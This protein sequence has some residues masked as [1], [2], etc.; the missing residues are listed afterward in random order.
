MHGDDLLSEINTKKTLEF[1]PATIFVSVVIVLG[2][3][4]NSMSLAFY[5]WKVAKTSTNFF[6]CALSAVDLITCFVLLGEVI[7]L[8]YVVNFPSVFLCK[9]LYFLNQW[10]VVTSGMMLFLVAMDRFRKICRPLKWQFTERTCRL[11]FGVFVAYGLALSFRNLWTVNVIAAR[12]PDDELN[13]TVNVSHCTL[14]FQNYNVAVQ[15]F[16]FLDLCSFVVIIG[17]SSVLY[18][19]IVRE[20][21][22]SRKRVDRFTRRIPNFVPSPSSSKA[23]KVI[24]NERR[25]SSDISC[26]NFV[27]ETEKTSV[28]IETA[29]TPVYNSQMLDNILL[30]RGSKRCRPATNLQVKTFEVEKKITF[31]LIVIT[32]VSL[33]SFLP[34]F[35]VNLALKERIISARDEFT[36]EVQFL[37]RMF[38]MNNAINP[39]VMAICN[40][41]FRLFIKTSILGCKGTQTLEVN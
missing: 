23:D 34:H 35:V 4:G 21:I 6:I 27:V 7:E 25:N 14:D 5:G 1:L 41:Q 15:F 32:V 31:M 19:F 36:V 13:Q 12:I 40:R 26:S 33:V 29:R 2:V 11:A 16:H 38:M 24:P 20:I 9:S 8:C 18:G 22:M 3:L 17:G 10:L 28:S 37:L 39:Y 30:R